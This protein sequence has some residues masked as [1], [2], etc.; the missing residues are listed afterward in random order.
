MHPAP[1]IL[2]IKSI[3]AKDK[4][5][6]TRPIIAKVKVFLAPSTC[7]GSPPDVI[8]LIPEKRIKKIETTAANPKIQLRTKEKIA[9]IQERVATSPFT[10]HSFGHCI[11]KD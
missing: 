8:N 9:G 11:R 1:V 3:I 7:F 5:T 4:S 10:K 2:L 6:T